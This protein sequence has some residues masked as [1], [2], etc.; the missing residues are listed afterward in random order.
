M[1]DP[2]ERERYSL[3]ALTNYQDSQVHRGMVESAGSHALD[4]YVN[5]CTSQQLTPS[6]L[7]IPTY[8]RFY[9]RSITMYLPQSH[10]S[11][12]SWKTFS[13]CPP[14]VWIITAT[15]CCPS[16]LHSTNQNRCIF[17]ACTSDRAE[18]FTCSHRM[19][20]YNEGVRCEV[21]SVYTVGQRTLTVA[22]LC[23]YVH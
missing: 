12:Q 23:S 7:Y 8:Y 4:M 11:R 15:Y 17:F 3:H 22:K 18:R 14:A 5:V 21:M 1:W 13:F 10:H 19:H 6:C 2:L 16:P 20:M 9:R